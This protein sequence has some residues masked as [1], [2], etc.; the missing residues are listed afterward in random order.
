MFAK[1]LHTAR[2]FLSRSPS[3][4]DLPSEAKVGT[5]AAPVVSEGHDAA[6]S[7]VTST[8]SG[9]VEDRTPV[10]SARKPKRTLD[11]E[12]T[13]IVIKKRRKSPPAN[14]DVS[15]QIEG[16]AEEADKVLLDSDTI[17]VQP[18]ESDPQ[19]PTQHSVKEKLPIRRRS[20]PKVVVEKRNTPTVSIDKVPRIEVP[21]TQDSEFYTPAIQLASSIYGTPMT[22]RKEQESSPTLNAKGLD[23][24]KTP[25]LNKKKYGKKNKGTPVATQSSAEKQEPEAELETASI[26]RGTYPEEIPSST[27]DTEI[28]ALST[29][30]ST[31][32]QN[33]PSKTKVKKAHVRFG[34]EELREAPVSS[35]QRFRFGIDDIGDSPKP[36]NST[37]VVDETD[38]ADDSD[39][40][41]E[42][43]EEVTAASALSKTKAAE[44]DAQ[45]AFRAQ[46]EKEKLKRRERANRVAAEQAQKRRKEEKKAEKLAAL[47]KK[48]RKNAPPEL[49]ALNLPDLLP[50]SILEA[51]GD[52]RPPTPPPMLPGQSKVDKHKEQLQ[53]HI[54]FLERGEQP[55]RDVKRGGINVHVLAQE[56]KLLAPKFNR[57]TRDIRE[58]FLK[59][60]QAE[61]KQKSGKRKIQFN[62]MERRP[63]GRGFLRDED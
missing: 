49:D 2:N 14:D 9:P 23:V 61:Q 55:I 15:E 40:S 7:M 35:G 57:N 28:G 19:T 20:S 63:V 22:T 50:L 30:D 46:Q 58:Q 6:P 12:E 26:V 44:A 45:R 41:D 36:A 38:E 54:K 37:P 43:P 56:N 27:M 53:R 60:R 29:Q 1:A 52:R 13:T 4:Q 25:M 24:V 16:V 18:P 11:I 34:S 48:D 47:E 3:A 31:K 21:A 51:A 32:K 39:D 42:A 59:G 8:R 5:Q 62:K 10:S 33:P 17:D